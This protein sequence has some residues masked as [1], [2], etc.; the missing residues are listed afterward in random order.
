MEATMKTSKNTKK[1][2]GLDTTRKKSAPFSANTQRRDWLLRIENEIR[3]IWA[4]EEA[5]TGKGIWE[6]DAPLS[7]CSSPTEDD[8]Y[9]VTFPYPYMNGR[10]HLG[11]AFTLAKAEFIAG[12]QRLQGKQTLFPFA[13]HATGMPIKV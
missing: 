7:G 1:Q 9:F 5:E 4:K 8:K 3:E 13:F 2:K 6:V 10:L 11:H 12:Y